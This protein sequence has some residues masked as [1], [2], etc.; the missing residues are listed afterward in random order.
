MNIKYYVV[1]TIAWA[2]K[3]FANFVLYHFLKVCKQ[4]ASKKIFSKDVSY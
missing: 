3:S 4:M 2:L 1:R